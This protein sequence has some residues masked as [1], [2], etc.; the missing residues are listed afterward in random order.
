MIVIPI[1]ALGLVYYYGET[2]PKKWAY[3]LL[4]TVPLIIILGVSVPLCVIERGRGGLPK[5]L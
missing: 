2:K 5:E 3:R 1:I 4:I